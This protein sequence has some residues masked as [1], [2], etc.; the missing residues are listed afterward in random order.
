[1][2]VEPFAGKGRNVTTDNSF[3][4][5]KLAK[6]LLLRK[7]IVFGTLDRIQREVPDS[8]K[9]TKSSLHTTKVLSLLTTDNT[10]LTSYRGKK[11]K[12]VLLLSSMHANLTVSQKGKHISETIE[13]YNATK[14]RVHIIDQKARHI[15]CKASCCRWPLQVFYNIPI[16]LTAINASILYNKVQGPKHKAK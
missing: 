7:T 9:S 13:I 2:L 5:L 10:T 11:N 8:L 15:S 16:E 14:Y 1:M 4:S 3:T 12:I 6:T